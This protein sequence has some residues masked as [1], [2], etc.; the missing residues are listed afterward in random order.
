MGYYSKIHWADYNGDSLNDLLVGQ[1]CDTKPGARI[2]VYPNIGSAHKPKL[3]TPQI[4]TLSGQMS[5]P[6]PYLADLDNDGLKDM[7]CGTDGRDIVFFK[8]TGTAQKPT[9]GQPVKLELQGPGFEKGYRRRL[10]V[11][12]WNEDGKPDLLM[13]DRFRIDKNNQGGHLWLFLGK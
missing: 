1:T 12:D 13:G 6:S 3:S 11:T 7:I 5:R 8:N 10:T 9:W 2:I 4:I